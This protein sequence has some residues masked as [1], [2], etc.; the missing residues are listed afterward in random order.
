MIMKENQ[1]IRPLAIYQLLKNHTD[2]SVAIGSFEIAQT[3]NLEGLPSSIKE[4]KDDLKLLK[5]WGFGVNEVQGEDLY[6]LNTKVFSDAEL[7]IIIDAI[8]SATFITEKK[9]MELVRKI[10]RL[11]GES[12]AQS[13]IN[14]SSFSTIKHTNENVFNAVATLDSC[15]RSGMKCSFL[16]FDYDVE[17]SRLYRKERR[18]YVVNPLALTFSEDKYYLLAYGDKYE[19]VASYRVDRMDKVMPEGENVTKAEWLKNFDLNAYKKQSFSMFKGDTKEVSL[20]CKNE[21]V[22]VVID[23]F[24][25]KVNMLKLNDDLFRVKVTVQ[26]S[27]TFFGWCATSGGRIKIVA[28]E[29]V[30]LAYYEHLS[31][32]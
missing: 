21:A 9:T 14:K 16:Y 4:V 32:C 8:E 27:P 17:G 13:L 24:G 31:K 22:D 23:K 18:R 10:S 19:N 7:R 6:Y 5:D 25:E 30:K 3:L 29:E 12:R 28:P 15:I 26:I 20:E 2:S 1:K 11:A